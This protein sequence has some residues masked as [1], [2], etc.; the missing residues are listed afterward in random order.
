[1]QLNHYWAFGGKVEF[2]PETGDVTRGHVDKK[3]AD[4][5]GSVWKQR[6]RWFAIWHDGESLVFQHR[7]ERW[8]LTPDVTLRVR[9]R[10]RRTFQILRDGDVEFQFA[11][12]FKGLIAANID[13]TYDRLEEESDDFFL[14]VTSMWIN[15]KDRSVDEFDA[16]VKEAG[17]QTR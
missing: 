15:W 7:R 17:L 10:Y 2:D 14:Y 16:L 11:Y 8:D 4:A 3:S 13:P 6:G 12:W 9:G 1:M 5:W